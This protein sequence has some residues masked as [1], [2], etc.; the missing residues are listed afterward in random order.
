VSCQNRS[1]SEQLRDGIRGID[2]RI[3]RVNH[4]VP[5]PEFNLDKNR[6]RLHSYWTG[7][8]ARSLPLIQIMSQ[9]KEFIDLNPTEVIFIQIGRDWTPIDD[10]RFCGW[11]R[12]D[13]CGP[14][15][16]RVGDRIEVEE[17][18]KV[19][20]E[21][22]EYY[23]GSKLCKLGD[24]NKDGDYLLRKDVKLGEL[25]DHGKQIII[26]QSFFG[27]YPQNNHALEEGDNLP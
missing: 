21:E 20:S 5:K 10:I 7:H 12:P 16:D 4:Q 27:I 14:G 23:F 25:V 24:K 3:Q 15:R 2:I 9:I 8:G 11:F 1:V 17:F 19:L 26:Y 18:M 22:I 13:I 6:N